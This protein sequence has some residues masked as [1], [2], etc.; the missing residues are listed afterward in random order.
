MK[1][2]SSVVELP[3]RKLKVV[4]SIP[5]AVVNAIILPQRTTVSVDYI[6]P[7]HNLISLFLSDC[8]PFRRD[9]RDPSDLGGM[10][11]TSGAVRQLN[12]IQDSL[13]VSAPLA[14]CSTTRPYFLQNVVRIE[15]HTS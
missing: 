2:R 1:M 7:Y 9:Q 12:R 5:G 6:C 15:H 4:R 10:R 3:L 13:M 14:L 8:I 11:L